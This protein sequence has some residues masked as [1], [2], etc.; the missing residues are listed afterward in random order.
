MSLP[1]LW[2]VFDSKGNLCTDA[3]HEQRRA[4]DLMP[5]VANVK[6]EDGPFRVAEVEVILC[7]R[8]TVGSGSR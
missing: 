7:F 2:A 4:N 3:V 6:P 1:H 5:L 8:P